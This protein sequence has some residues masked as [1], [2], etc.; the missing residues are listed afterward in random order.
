MDTKDIIVF[1]AILV[2][3]ALRLYQKY[4]KDKGKNPENTAGKKSGDQESAGN[5]DYEPYSGR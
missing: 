1:S 5:D 2:F 4:M 3:V